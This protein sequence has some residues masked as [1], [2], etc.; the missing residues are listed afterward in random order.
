MQ[1]GD[2]VLMAAEKELW[3]TNVWLA[4]TKPCDLRGFR[5]NLSLLKNPTKTWL[6]LPSLSTKDLQ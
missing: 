6:P 4:K 3:L 5:E 1:H 2:P